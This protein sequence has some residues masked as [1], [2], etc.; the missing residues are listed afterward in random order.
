M[1]T[2]SGR[3]WRTCVAAST[4]WA[5]SWRRARRSPSAPEPRVSPGPV[6]ILG[7]GLMGGSLGLALAGDRE[8]VGADPDPEALRTALRMGAVSRAAA[9]VEEAAEGADAVVL[10]APVP[11]LED[12]ARRALAATADD[13]LVTDIGSAKSALLAA[14]GPGERERFIGG[15]PLCG[16]AR[17]RGGLAP[18]PPL[19][20]A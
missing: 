18:P 17:A 5:R 10:A 9:T 3:G 20:R 4:S 14:L 8:V 11:A 16:A 7:V 12:L 13:C 19:P 6:A 1:R 15:H 2:P